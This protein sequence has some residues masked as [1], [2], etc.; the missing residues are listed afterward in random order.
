MAIKISHLGIAVRDLAESEALFKVLLG[1]EHVHRETVLDQ[2]VNIASLKLG[3]SLI[4]LTEPMNEASP[5]AGFLAK[6]GEGI[7]HIAIEVED[8]EQELRRVEALG[9]RLIDEH[10]RLG[11]HGMEIAFLHPKS[12]NGVLIEF[13]SK[14]RE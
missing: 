7:H 8:V 10:P 1:E 4:E 2:G 12:T 5:I 11:A 14:P 13:C 6:R 9:I 3:D